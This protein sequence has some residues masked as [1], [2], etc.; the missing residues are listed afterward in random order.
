MS[1]VDVIIP[2]YKYAHYLVECVESVLGQ[3]HHDLRVLIIDDASPD[4][5]PDVAEGLTARDGRVEY[6]RHEANKGHIATYNEGLEWTSGDYTLLLSADDL[7]VPGAIERA[8]RV[9]DEQPEVGFI[10]GKAIWFQSEEPKPAFRTSAGSCE[11]RVVRGQDWLEGVC[12]EGVNPLTS[13]EVMVRTSL[14]RGLGG[15]RPELTHSGDMEMWMRFAANGDVGVIE[16]DQAYYRIHGKAMSLGY[17]KAKDA[18]TIRMAL[19]DYWQ[20]KGAFDA[21]FRG[22]GDRIA[23]RARLEGLA[24]QGLSWDAFWSAHKAFEAGDKQTCQEFLDFAAQVY[25]ELTERP[26]WSRMRWKRAVGSRAWSTIRPI[27]GWIRSRSGTEP[28]CVAS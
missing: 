18:T 1:R 12:R 7:L 2:C 11:W 20:R 26:E 25:P 9:M 17:V 13:P 6:R 19:G 8:V 15:Y 4:N 22:Q 14:Q 28:V 24:N 16:A 21:V 3:S 27:L 23:G 5:T 10:Y